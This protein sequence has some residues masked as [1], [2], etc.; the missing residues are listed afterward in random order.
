MVATSDSTPTPPARMQR[1]V[2]ETVEYKGVGLHSGKEIKITMV[3][4]AL[5]NKAGEMYAISTTER[6]H[7]GGS[8]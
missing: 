3:S 7:R 8:S 4:T 6:A 2:K 5:I 1:T